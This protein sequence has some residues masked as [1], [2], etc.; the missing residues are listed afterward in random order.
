MSRIIIFYF[1]IQLQNLLDPIPRPL[2]SATLPPCLAAGMPALNPKV[3]F[4]IAQGRFCY[5]YIFVQMITPRFTLTQDDEFLHI[6]IYAPFT[7]LQVA[8]T[9][10]NIY[11]FHDLVYLVTIYFSFIYFSF[12]TSS[13]MKT[14]RKLNIEKL[15]CTIFTIFLS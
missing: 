12:T 14:I 4:F 2:R 7:N 1:G 8:F 10:L 5:L 6:V 9:I 15:K 11:S 13:F 3:K